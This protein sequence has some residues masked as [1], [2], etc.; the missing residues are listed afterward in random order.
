MSLGSRLKMA[1]KAKRLTQK[2]LG[3]LVSVTGSA[4]G[5]Y[6]SGVSSPN[7]DILIRLMEILNIDANFLYADDIVNSN[8][9]YFLTPEE[10][11]LL[12]AFRALNSEGQRTALTTILSLTTNPVLTEERGT[13]VS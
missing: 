2:Q 3:D 7:E 1:R 4:I 10:Q 9:M 11:Q 5:N 6:E 8:D 13:G 12:S